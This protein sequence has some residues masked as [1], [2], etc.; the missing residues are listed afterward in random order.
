MLEIEVFQQNDPGAVLSQFFKHLLLLA[1]KHPTSTEHA[2]PQTIW[3]KYSITWTIK[4]M[5]E[6]LNYKVQLQCSFVAF[7]A[8]K[9][10]KNNS[11]TTAAFFLQKHF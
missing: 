7:H 5:E 10:K 11:Y 8:E 1:K 9:H 2:M 6:I 3:N 4:T